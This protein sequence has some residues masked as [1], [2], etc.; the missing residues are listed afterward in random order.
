MK[1]RPSPEVT[2]ALAEADSVGPHLAAN[3]GLVV[4]FGRIGDAFTP[5]DPLAEWVATVSLAANDLNLLSA[6]ITAEDGTRPASPT[7]L[8]RVAASHFFEI[9]KYLALRRRQPMVIAFIERMG[10]TA[11]GYRRVLTVYNEHITTLATIRD[12]SAFHYG[13]TSVE[14]KNP[15]IRRALI[16]VAEEQGEIYLNAGPVAF[17]FAQELEAAIFT[18]SCGGIEPGAREIGSLLEEVASAAT[19]FDEFAHIA[20]RNFLQERDIGLTAEGIRAADQ[21]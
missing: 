1:P 5:G 19:E 15:L 21:A 14:K 20:I 18:I 10:E 17:G 2:A 8:F 4:R 13:P 12:N 16:A 3:D 9:G 6:W 7:Y 11:R